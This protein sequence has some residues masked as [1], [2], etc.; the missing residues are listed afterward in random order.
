MI[1][2]IYKKIQFVLTQSQMKEL[3][4]IFSL[5]LI[6]VFFEILGIGMIIPVMNII[7][8]DDIQNKYPYLIFIFEFL[9]FPNKKEL[10]LY[11]LIFLLLVYGVKNIFL[12]YLTWKKGNFTFNL[13][14]DISKR[15]LNL[16]LKQSFSFHV[17]KNSSE[18][19]QNV[20]IETR[21]FGKGFIL[22]II[23][24]SVEILVYFLYFCF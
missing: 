8:E 16:Y 21:H 19:I 10:I 3:L 6:G 11:S 9:G 22:S 12:A 20:L 13:Y 15:L 2:N 18:L 23:D 14:A 24:L 5:I 1:K 7:V 17:N 4:L